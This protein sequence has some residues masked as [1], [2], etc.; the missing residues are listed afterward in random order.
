MIQV[1]SNRIKL[2]GL[3]VEGQT[4]YEAIPNILTRIGVKYTSPSCFHGQPVEASIPILVE[5]CLLPSAR[6]QLL[7]G[8]DKVIVILDLE[9]RNINANEFKQNVLSELRKKIAEVEGQKFAHK[10]EVV[11]C[12][13][14]FENWLISDPEGIYRS[15]YIKKNLVKVVNCHADGLDALS[16]LRSAFRTGEYYNRSIHGPRIAKF[17]RVKG[18]E[19]NHIC[20]ESFREFIK[21]AKMV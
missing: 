19:L 5:N 15:N 7:K 20:S 17:L 9:Y 21:I 8:V 3:I 10:V 18:E 11:I 4:E 2:I 6:I 14:K 1:R 13:K 12:N 16:V